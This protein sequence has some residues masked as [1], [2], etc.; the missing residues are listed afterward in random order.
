MYLLRDGVLEDLNI[1]EY[2]SGGKKGV[3]TPDDTRSQGFSVVFRPIRPVD[4]NLKGPLTDMA[5]PHIISYNSV[6]TGPVEV[7]GQVGIGFVHSK[8]P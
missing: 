6:A 5:H 7:T 8:M 4:H 2:V 3:I 1:G